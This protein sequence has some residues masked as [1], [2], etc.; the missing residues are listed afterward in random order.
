MQ[1]LIFNTSKKT[2]RL[3]DGSRG[4]S[5]EI[6]TFERIKTVKVLVSSYEAIQTPLEEHLNPVP[7]LRVPISNTNM[8][9]ENE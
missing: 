8:I 2:I 9:I 3:L 1:T 6:E 4:N 7:V 5:K